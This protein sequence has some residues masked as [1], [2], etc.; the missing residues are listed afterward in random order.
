[1]YR[2][3]YIVSSKTFLLFRK[4][5]FSR[6]ATRAVLV[7][8]K[9]ANVYYG[10]FNT[11]LLVGLRKYNMYGSCGMKLFTNHKY[12]YTNRYI[13]VHLYMNSE[14]VEFETGYSHRYHP[15]FSIIAKIVS[16]ENEKTIHCIQVHK[17][18]AVHNKT[19]KK[20]LFAHILLQQ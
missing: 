3:G 16:S 18:S 17:I 13:W 15:T 10:T 6:N 5:L 20:K 9:P 19:N 12:L 11:L 14:Y 8:P 2:R 4:S 7:R 1:M